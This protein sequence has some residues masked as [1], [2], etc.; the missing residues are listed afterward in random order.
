MSD[1]KVTRIIV[2]GHPTGIIGLQPI[3]EEVAKEFTGRTDDEIK[4]ELLTR[5]SKKNYI[6]SK[7][8]DAYGQAFLIEYKKLVGEPFADMEAG[9]LEIK[10]LGMGCPRCE[11]GRR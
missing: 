9:C 10:V 3:L 11:K 2:G 4:D 6:S 1:N 5:L 8:K 7:T